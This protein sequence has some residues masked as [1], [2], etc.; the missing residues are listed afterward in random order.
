M[1]ES[2]FG[3]AAVD[4]RTLKFGWDSSFQN[5]AEYI[6]IVIGVV[7]AIAMGWDTS[8][9]E[10]M[11][12]SEIALRWAS[13]GRFRSDNV[14]NAAT[15]FLVICASKDVHFMDSRHIPKEENWHAV[16]FSRTEEGETW[17]QL[18]RRMR[19]R[20]PD[21][22]RDLQEVIV[23]NLP[24]LLDLCEPRTT[25]EDEDSFGVYWRRV[26]QFVDALGPRQN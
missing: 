4:L 1:F 19:R 20:D 7:G 23:P 11:G 24:E 26:H 3:G 14:I 9:I 6:T 15:V 22:P 10:I 18:I 12:D 5:C 21:I 16:M 25:F 13:S 2:L 8:A 17:D